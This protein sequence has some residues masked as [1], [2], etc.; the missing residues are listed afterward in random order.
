MT[1]RREI[2]QTG[3]SVPAWPLALNGLLSSNASARIA[4][5]SVTVRKVVFDGR[6]TQ[7]RAFADAVAG[8]GVPVTTL[9]EGD[10]T[11]IWDELDRLWRNTP[12]AIAGLTQYWPLFALERLAS[13]RGLRVVLRIE[14]EPRADGTLAHIMT[15]PSETLAMAAHLGRQDVAWPVLT[16]AVLTHCRADGR[17][18]VERTIVTRADG[19]TLERASGPAVSSLQRAESVIHY[20]TPQAIQE[21]RGVARDAPLLSWLIAP[22]A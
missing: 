1:N 20:Y 5:D 22:R 17:G 12:M 14:H 6:Y 7:G 8:L 9:D 18:S 3:M 10:V 16:A 21:G 13:E 11:R 15:G 4:E 2:L 19:P